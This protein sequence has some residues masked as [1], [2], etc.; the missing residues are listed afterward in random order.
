MK[1][2]TYVITNENLNI[3]YK[4]IDNLIEILKKI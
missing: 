1:L 2:A 4:T 3:T